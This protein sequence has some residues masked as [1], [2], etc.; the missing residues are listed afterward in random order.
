MGITEVNPLSAHY[1]C[2]KCNEVI[3]EED[4]ELLGSKYPS[5]YD[6]PD[7]Y[8]KCGEK[9][10]KEGQDMPFATFLGFDGD[11]APDIDL[12]FSSE[13]QSRAHDYTKEL[14]GKDYVYRAGTI[15]TVAEKTAFG[16][17]I[18]YMEEKNRT[19]RKAE[20]ERL[21]QGLIGIKRTTGQHPGGIV[22]IPN[23]MDVFDFTPYQYPADDPNSS[24]YTTHF[25]FSAIHDYVL[26]LDILGHDDPTILKMLEDL[27]GVKVDDIPFDDSEVLKIFSSPEPLGVTKEQI[28]CE[29]GTLGIPEFGTNF[30]IE[31][32]K[33][34]K[35]VSF[36]ELVKFQV[37]RMVLTCG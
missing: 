30:V 4:G 21:A 28:E 14:F 29:T 9:F 31:M 27:T 33:D 32:L 24:W 25:E 34:T 6:L 20:I 8:C 18:G 22:I 16:F 12:N 3:F 19:P 11:K 2:P 35:P 7:R 15:G 17:V 1:I 23:Y 37:Y 13:Y 5:G 10:K 36:A 26:K